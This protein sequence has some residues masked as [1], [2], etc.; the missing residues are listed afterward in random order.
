MAGNVRRAL[1]S[2]TDKT[3]IAELA[4]GLA[5]L[6]VELLSTGGT[7][8][9]IRDAGVQVR[10]LSDFTG[11]PEMLDGRV[12]TLHP[13]VFGG[14][15]ARR[16]DA[17]HRAQ[18]QAHGIEPIDLVVVNLYDFQGALDREAEWNELI[19]N[20]DIGGPSLLRA[21][22]KNHADVLVLVDPSDYDATLSTLKSGHDVD[23]QT[24]ARLATKVYAHTARYDALIAQGLGE[25]LDPDASTPPFLGPTLRRR[26]SLRY[27]EN[28]HQKAGWYESAGGVTSGLAAAETLQGKE[29]SYNNLLDLDAAFALA[30]D[31]KAQFARTAAI[32]IKHNNPCGAALGDSVAEAI[33]TSRACDPVSAFGAVVAVTS[34]LDGEAARVLTEA[35]VEAVV[36]PGY[37]D[38]ARAVLAKKKNLR[39]LALPAA[40]WTIPARS[41]LLLRPVA[42]GYLAQT[43]DQEASFV[44]EVVR[45]K[46]VTERAPDAVDQTAL[47]FAWTVAKHV[48][49]NAIVF[50]REDRVVAVGA[51]QMSRVDSVK[52][53]RLKAGEALEGA[54]V[55]SD[56]FF[57]FRDGVDVLAEAGARAIVQP[58]GSI[59]DEE[60]VAAANEHGLSMVF[61]HF[62]HFRH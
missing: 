59:R 12:K 45:G 31:M 58:G 52:I 27:G 19:E 35:F 23:V 1:L 32:F 34:P 5:E 26:Q 13:K 37:D 30:V 44:D 10:D 55:A 15:L 56:A 6:G 8:R 50:A 36:A 41:P 46:V 43:Q 60:V 16:D 40:H 9:A 4:S 53:C 28:P 11:T 51:G 14:I 24:R 20:I 21:S 62:R 57:P 18:M 42:G 33:A 38:D 7:A 2:V 39:V 29:L 47:R 22:A 49:S 17:D 25:R 61:T 3:G 48:R 54:V